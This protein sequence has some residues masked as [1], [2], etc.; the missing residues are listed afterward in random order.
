MHGHDIIVIGTSAGGLE[1]L[2]LIARGLPANLPAAVFIV[3]HLPS[4]GQTLMPEILGNVSGLT[5]VLATDRMPITH[6]T[7]YVARP[8]HHLI[9]NEAHIHLVRG[10][11]ENGF[12]PAID[13]LF[14]TAARAYGRRV[15]GVVLTGLLDDG[16]AGLLAIKRRGGV[17]LVQDPQ[18]AGFPSMPETAIRYVDVDAVIATAAIPET[19]TR[20]AHQPVDE[21]GGAPVSDEL[22][23]ES[24]ISKMNPHAIQHGTDYA[25][26]VPLSCPDCGGVMA[27]FYDGSLLR[28]RCQT[29][30]VYSRDSYFTCQGEMLDHSLWAAFNSL[31]ERAELAR[32][33]I[34]DARAFNDNLSERRFSRLLEQVEEQKEVL[35]QL[36]MTDSDE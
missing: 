34:R 35:R 15:V 24:E 11:R 17:A 12:R 29:G 3:Q 23:K 14:R 22:E 9:V 13:V 20:L 2:M 1:P 21:E 19:L 31:A 4:N 28:F 7:I 33:L 32:R 8:D 5:V 16:T 26:N 27:E 30:H 25:I 6:G 10:P 36:L 18:E